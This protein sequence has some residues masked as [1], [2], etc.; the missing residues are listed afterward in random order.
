MT[1]RLEEKTKR[2]A[3]LLARV[4][5]LASEGP[6]D[7]PIVGLAYDSRKVQAGYLFV[8]IRGFHVDGHAYIQQALER[9]A[10]AVV[11]EHED[12][13]L[14]GL[15]SV[16]ALCR[17]Q[18]ATVVRVADSRVVLS[19][20]AA[21]LYDYPARELLVVGITGTK[22]KTTTTTLTSLVLDGGGHRSG[23]MTTVDF[24]I[25]DRW[26]SNET[27]QTTP[28]AP[29][30]QE[31][32][33]QMAD[34]GCD[35]AV[36]ESSS[37]ALSPRW[38]RL[39][40]CEYDVAVFTNVTHEH[41][42]YHGTFEQYRADKAQLFAL[43]AASAPEKRVGGALRRPRKTA[44]VNLDDPSAEVFLEHAG[45][46]EIITYGV[47]REDAMVRAVD[48]AE[49]RDGISLT[50]ITPA[51]R[52]D[53]RLKMLGTFNVPNVLAAISVGI[54][55]GIPLD[56]CRRALEAVPGVS[57][58]MERIDQGQPFTVLVDYA[59]NPDS[60][61]KLMSVMRPLTTGQLISVFG[62]GGERDRQKR[63]IQGAIA[64]RYC[65]FVVLTDE[66]PRLEDRHAIID[67]IAVGVEDAGKREG[68]GYLK[69]ADRTDAIRAAFQR[70]QPGDIV[71]LLGKGHESCILYA[72]RVPYDE[73][74]VARQLLAEL[75]YRV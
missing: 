16:I 40:D 52:A 50:V 44:I 3:D 42:D 20:I 21:A 13:E 63:P 11:Y 57:G 5:P 71:L 2:L 36:V 64:A 15:E 67:E 39:G 7:V 24:K 12:V 10:A 14:P 69:I 29:E 62:S 74:E 55:Q 6:L 38:N 30:V 25:G 73:R 66:D 17:R 75:G 48:V 31:L 26:W 34:E 47:Q 70:A 19:P 37:H 49:S 8:A 27:R 53:I 4:T 60:F 54:S 58:R 9:G 22:G 61:E 68:E 56:A 33:R 35:Y 46:A 18:G 45:G 72:Q 32:L 51:E 23:L 28:E 1:T 65:D 59:H 41:L 43:M